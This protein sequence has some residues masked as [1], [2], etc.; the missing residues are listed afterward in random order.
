MKNK[1]TAV[2]LCLFFG[3]FGIHKFYLGNN[4]LGLLY[5]IFCWTGIP[6]ILAFID[7]FILIFTSEKSFNQ[8]YNSAFI[9]NPY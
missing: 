1:G 3:F 9:R 5:L 7:F 4:V 6:L 8:R 2:V